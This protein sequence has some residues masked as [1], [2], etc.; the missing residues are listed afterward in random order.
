MKYMSGIWNVVS[1]PYVQ[2]PSTNR[3]LWI[4]KGEYVDL[5]SDTV[6]YLACSNTLTIVYIP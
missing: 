1:K 4:W 2:T 6:Q 3:P 5:V